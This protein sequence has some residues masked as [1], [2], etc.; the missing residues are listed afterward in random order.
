MLELKNVS[1]FY[2]N[3]GVIASGFSKINLKLDMGEFVVITG[4]SGSGKSTLLNVISGLDTYEE[5]EMYI[6]GEET[7]H[8]TETGFE[9]YRKQYIANIFQNFNLINSYTV[10][11]NI[12]FILLLNGCKKK[13]IKNKVIDLIKKV[14]LYKFKNTKVSKLSGGQKQR[15]AIAR[16]LAKDTP[17]IVADE[18][19][20]NLDTKSAESVLKLLHEISKNKLVIVVTHNFEQVEK[21]AT[22]VIKMHD[23]KILEDRLVKNVA[24]ID[25]QNIEEYGSIT[26][27]N[28]L[29]IGIR[30]TFNI[31]VKFLLLFA[32][33][34][35]ISLAIFS[36][37]SSIK[38]NEYEME[39]LGYNIF[40]N[41]TSENRV[42]VKKQDK[43]A[44]TEEDIQQ[45]ELLDNIKYLIKE[46]SILDS[47][48]TFS[49]NE[50]W[51]YG[52]VF[53]ISVAKINTVDIGRIPETT[54]EVIVEGT[55]GDFNLNE[56][57]IGTEMYLSNQYINDN[58]LKLKIVGIKY[59]GEIP[60]AFNTVMFEE[61]K[62]YVSDEVLQILRKQ[63]NQANS[64]IK[65]LFENKYHDSVNYNAQF[66]VRP[67]ENV[68]QGYAMVSS[69]LNYLCTN[70]SCL[71]KNLTIYVENIY[72][73]DEVT[74]KINKRYSKYNFKNLTGSS[75][76]YEINNGAIYINPDDY[77][78][79]FNKPAYQISVF[80]DNME[81]FD[82][83]V[84]EI[85]SLGF[86][87]LALKDT[88]V[89]EDS[90]YYE[91]L[92]L[93]TRV[94]STVIIIG[95]LFIAYFVIKII[96][97]SRN[98]Y[99]STLR[100]IGGSKKLSKQ[101]LDIELFINS[102][103]AY[104]FVLAII[105]CT[106]KQIIAWEYLKN[107]IKFLEI[108]DYIIVYLV[109]I[110]VSQI[111]AKRFSKSLFKKSAMKTLQEKE[112]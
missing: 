105:Y 49:N 51:L 23:G 64:T 21:Y 74:L 54:N 73:K 106:N 34:L 95:V 25:N 37:Y 72:Y 55:M 110:I 47:S 62:F 1:K 96:L 86:S 52:T 100:A 16:A 92:K 71:N 65:V 76:D 27:A 83:T 104:I 8:Y 45:I 57:L 48:M 88:K 102:T 7:S 56:D 58:A 46:D 10:Y 75:T 77:S 89:D 68:K 94:I 87:T 63:N 82:K 60:K 85:K 26:F 9:E 11:Q 31:K 3:K 101:L 103:L 4:E 50:N 6:N 17:I 109:L 111:I 44:F 13:E 67:N 97:K 28:K 14:D 5:G 79:L 18:P 39:K 32:V 78:N 80:I 35:F 108:K 93:I 91:I 22:R 38:K 20:G 61:Q 70:G 99:F 66:N 36:Q 98:T 41:D 107:I 19:T 15:V 29:I 81:E 42:I 12:E 33:F 24:K 90:G 59:K 112:V 2:Y 30:N 53:P 84:L 40:F 43:S 69:D